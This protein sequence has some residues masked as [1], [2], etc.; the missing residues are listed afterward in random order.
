TTL[1]RSSRFGVLRRTRRWRGIYTITQLVLDGFVRFGCTIF[2]GIA[3]TAGSIGYCILGFTSFF[4]DFIASSLGIFLQGVGIFLGVF[5]LFLCFFFDV[6]STFSG[7]P[8]Q[9]FRVL[10]HGPVSVGCGRRGR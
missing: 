6:V 3:R 2:N 8:L 1:F 9:F 5:F 10:L 4:S 7:V